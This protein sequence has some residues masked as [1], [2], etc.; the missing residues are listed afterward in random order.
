MLAIALFAFFGAAALASVAVLADS[1]LRGVAAVRRLRGE[2]RMLGQ[3]MEPGPRQRNVHVL[4]IRAA[5]PRR[6]QQGAL[7]ALRAAA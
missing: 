5:G 1:G 3:A 4:V 2:L 6:A 7:P